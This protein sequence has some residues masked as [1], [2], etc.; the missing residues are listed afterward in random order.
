MDAARASADDVVH[1]G[2]K[3]LDQVAPRRLGGGQRAVLHRFGRRC[4][5]ADE[6][7]APKAKKDG[8]TSGIT[9]ELGLEFA[10]APAQDE[11]GEL[12][13]RAA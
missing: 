1:R 12:G 9:G 4:P 13:G 3:H 8:T 11:R 2:R 10:Q 5:V 7:D 6:H